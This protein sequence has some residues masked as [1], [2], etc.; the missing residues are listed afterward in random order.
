MARDEWYI[1]SVGVIVLITATAVAVLS[2][3]PLL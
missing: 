1:C 2:T 3:F